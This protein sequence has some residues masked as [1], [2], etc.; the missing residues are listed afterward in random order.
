MGVDFASCLDYLG[1]Y[2]LGLFQK[3]RERSLMVPLK[4]LVIKRLVSTGDLK[5]QDCIER[6][7]RSSSRFQLVASLAEVFAEP[8]FR[9]FY[10]LRSESVS[11]LSP[12]DDNVGTSFFQHSF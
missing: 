4:R 9:A 2:G 6:R 3:V 5:N 12:F 7:A 1:L 11:G 8:Y 10:I